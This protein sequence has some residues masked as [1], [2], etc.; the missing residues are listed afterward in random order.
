M[1]Q[2]Q[3][4]ADL[5][6]QF[7]GFIPTL[8][9]GLLVIALGLAAGWLAKRGTMRLLVW[10]RLDRIAAR[11][12]WRAAFGK[13]DVRA[14]LYRLVSNVVMIVVTLIFVDDALNRWGLTALALTLNRVVFYLPNLG[15][16]ALIVF[17][18]IAVSAALSARVTTALEEEGIRR[19]RLVGKAV[20]AALIA[21]VVA[22][23]L[24]QLQLARE[25]VLG[26]FLISFGSIGIAFA[27][28]VGLGTSRAIERG[29]VELLRKEGE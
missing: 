26:A 29:I 16:V 21:V 3:P 19:A 24:W 20:K 13:G 2:T 17:I 28:G 4:L 9:A 12:G 7:T 25:I 6:A 18:G 8:L 23:A 22:L 11:A 15:I 5:W 27:L 1:E 14:T 10:L